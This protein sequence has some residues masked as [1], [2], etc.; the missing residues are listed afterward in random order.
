MAGEQTKVYRG[1]N[2]DVL[3]VAS[4]GSIDIE[5]GGKITAAGTQ[6]A[7][8]VIPADATGGQ[9]PTEAEFNA[10]LAAVRLINTALQGAGIT[11]AS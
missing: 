9:D 11:A 7:V 2:G 4:G 1:S 8:I 10:L 5:A 3:S 6:A